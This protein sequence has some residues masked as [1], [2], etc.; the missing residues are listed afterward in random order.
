M[1]ARLNA[2]RVTDTPSA[3]VSTGLVTSG[4]QP[5]QP[6]QGFRATP[7]ELWELAKE[8]MKQHG[9]ICEPVPGLGDDA[10]LT[11]RGDR[12]AQ[13]AWLTDGRLAT[14]G[15]TSLQAEKGWVIASARAIAELVGGQALT[16]SESAVS[17]RT[18]E[19]SR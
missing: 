14:V 12:T 9:Q 11:L 15:V 7:S 8:T 6:S 10:I 3:L 19:E 16:G 1:V 5:S 4:H 13:V 17:L 2:F 18:R